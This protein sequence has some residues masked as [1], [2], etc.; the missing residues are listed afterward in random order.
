LIVA[1]GQG[2]VSP[3]EFSTCPETLETDLE[4]VFAGGDCITGPSNAVKAVEA[5]RKAAI[6]VD[7][8]LM[9]KAVVGDPACYRHTM[10]ELAEVPA[11][12]TA[13]Y[14][15]EERAAMPT[16]SPKKRKTS[17]EEIETGLTEALVQSEAQRCMAC[18]CRDAHECKLRSYATLFAA[19]ADRYQG[20]KREYDLD[21]SHPEMV[22]E[23]NKCI[24]CL[25]CVRITEELLGTS[26]LTVVGRG[27]TA[28]V[29]P[30]AGGE[31]ALVTDAGL[32]KIVDSCPVGALTRKGD[33]VPTLE[34]AFKRPGGPC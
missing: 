8:Y 18:G 1:I 28:R 22:Y 5:G 21:E 30:A 10:G 24:Q 33:K 12:V 26:S 9:G 19:E 29:K 16:V 23:S 34:P 17:Y 7:Q 14:A 32:T 20:K 25:T 3:M 11:E 31:M 27:F 4:G 15:K 6:S 13:K 2:V